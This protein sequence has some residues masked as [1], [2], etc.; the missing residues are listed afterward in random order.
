MHVSQLTLYIGAVFILAIAPGPDNIQVLVRGI[1]QGRMAGFVAACGFA[2]GVIFH[3]TI[4]AVGLAAVLR[5]SPVAFQM[6][7]YAGAAYLF[8]IGI[9]SWRS[10]S[11]S[12]AGN[13]PKKSLWLVF[14]QCV[15]GNMLNPKVTLFF[16]VF[17]PQFVQKN[18]PSPA[19]QMMILGGIFMMM[20]FL[21]FST[22]GIFA[23]TVGAW[24]K[25]N[26]KAGVWLDRLAGTTFIGVG[27]KVAF[28][29]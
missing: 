5:A 18:G 25:R 17:L 3:T 11:L 1:S 23:G 13:A 14:R 4:A 7:K 15:I 16:L 9:K 29:D 8:W 19:I 28:G 2:F 21:V 12:V 20:A 10:G 6:I 24:L 27:L 22:I 26:P